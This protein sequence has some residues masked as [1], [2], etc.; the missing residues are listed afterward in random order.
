[1][2]VELRLNNNPHCSAELENIPKSERWDLS[3]TPSIAVRGAGFEDGENRLTLIFKGEVIAE[4]EIDIT[5]HG[6]VKTAELSAPLKDPKEI[7]VR[8]G[9]DFQEKVPTELRRLHGTV[10]HFDNTVV[11]RPV[12]TTFSRMV[13]V[14]DEKGN[15]EIFLYGRERSIG[16]F[17]KD[18]SAATLE[19]WL[20]DVDLRGDVELAVRIDKL[21]VYELDAWLAH[22]GVYLHF[23]PMS[24]TRISELMKQG[25]SGTEV[26]AYPE[27]WPH[28]GKEDVKVFINDDEVITSTFNEYDDFLGEHNG[29][30]VS[31]PGYIVCIARENWKPGIIRVEISHRAQAGDKEILERGEGYYFGFAE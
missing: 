24:L 23:L 20:N 25:V 27:A 12:I 30:A 14:G 3:N 10:K 21:E 26:V 8:V 11:P 19:C 29:K 16:I 15:F 13:A 1:M 7:E 2:R 28:L 22:T 9:D 6:F 17:D 18:Y 4:E 5:N 31:R